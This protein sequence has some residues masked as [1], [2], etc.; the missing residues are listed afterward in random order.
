M[1]DL[2]LTAYKV[3]TAEQMATLEQEES[4]AGAPVDLADGYIHLS[5]AEQLTETVDKHFAGQSDLHVAAVDLGSFGA[6]LK[7]EE[8]RGGQLFPHLYGG[9]LLLE[10]VIAY[11]PLERDADGKVKLPVAG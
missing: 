1:S 11:G 9:P 2:P 4:F 5:T 10:T 8:S 6:G 3:L 7:W